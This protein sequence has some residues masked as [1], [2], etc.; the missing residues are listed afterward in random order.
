MSII[1]DF[2]LLNIKCDCFDLIVASYAYW[3]KGE[4]RFLFSNPLGLGI[5]DNGE[6]LGNKVYLNKGDIV[7]L[8]KQNGIDILFYTPEYKKLRCSVN[9]D[10]PVIVELDEYNCYWRKNYHMLHKKHYVVLTNYSLSSNDYFCIDMFPNS[11]KLTLTHEFITSNAKGFISFATNKTRIV[12][13]QLQYA[14]FETVNKFSDSKA[15]EPYY[16]FID[17]IQNC[18]LLDE[19]KGY[20]NVDVI[21][22]P[23]VWKLKNIIFS[24]C[25]FKYYMEYIDKEKTVIMVDVLNKIKQYWEIATN[26][27]IISFFRNNYEFPRKKVNENLRKAIK[28]MRGFINQLSFF[29]NENINNN[30]SL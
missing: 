8:A 2:E 10:N 14:F 11:K 28:E 20:D 1:N 19:I 9:K 18:S 22:V 25:Q 6:P 5:N 21:N 29:S 15:W 16:T 27:I 26:I 7:E 23:L 13:P 24:Y 12:K 4:Y 30:S 3:T 17:E